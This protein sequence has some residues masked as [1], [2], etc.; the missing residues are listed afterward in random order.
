MIAI[1]DYD[2]GNIKSVEK[3]LQYLG[4]ET[5]VSRDSQV[6]LKEDKVLLPGVGSFG[7]SM[8]KLK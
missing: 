3:A 5:V 4:Q 6:P 8:E 7:D 2:A 1:I